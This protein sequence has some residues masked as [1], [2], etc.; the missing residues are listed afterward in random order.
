MID[1]AFP[2]LCEQIAKHLVKK[3]T[4]NFVNSLIKHNVWKCAIFSFKDTHGI[5][6]KVYHNRGA[7]NMT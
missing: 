1:I 5:K 3:C 2:L 6:F 4:D 7:Q